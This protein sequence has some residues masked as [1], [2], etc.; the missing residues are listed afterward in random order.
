MSYEIVEI[1]NDF[2]S[3]RLFHHM[4][5]ADYDALQAVAR[6]LIEKGVKP[7]LL[8]VAEDFEGWEKA[9]G[10]D[11]VSFLSD[12]GDEVVKMAV[13]ADERWEEQVFMFAGKGL[14]VTEIKL[15]APSLL[16]EAE[17]WVRA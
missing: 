10:W 15:F 9:E 17:S 4:K 2:L 8:V 12:Y 14:R 11:D 16:Q 3:I 6:D 13:V 7:R 5:L 1:D